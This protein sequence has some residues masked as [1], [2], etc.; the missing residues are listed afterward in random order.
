MIKAYIRC[1]GGDYFQ[2]ASCPFDGWSSLEVV[3]FQAALDAMSSKNQTPSIEAFRLMGVSAAALKRII[4]VEFGNEAASF[5]ALSPKI[6]FKDGAERK[7]G[8]FGPDLT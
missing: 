6:Y 3:E 4:V 2:G 1:N 7:L 5:E 8:N